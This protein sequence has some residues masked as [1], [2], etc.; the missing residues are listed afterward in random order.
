MEQRLLPP[1]TPAPSAF[2]KAALGN[3][4]GAGH[5]VVRLEDA[6]P[7]EK[8]GSRAL[9]FFDQVGMEGLGEAPSRKLVAGQ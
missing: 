8:G 3:R 4:N 1:P 2:R 6:F 5:S 7:V 9:S